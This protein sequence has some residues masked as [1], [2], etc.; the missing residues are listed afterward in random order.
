MAVS[1]LLG[2][3]RQKGRVLWNGILPGVLVAV[4]A[5]GVSEHLLIF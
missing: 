4:V 3:H 1:V 5:H 2:I